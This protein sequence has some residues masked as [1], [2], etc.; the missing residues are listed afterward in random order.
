M[1]S[2]NKGVA[3]KGGGTSCVEEGMYRDGVFGSILDHH[4]YNQSVAVKRS[5]RRLFG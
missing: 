5:W 1:P 2:I 4:W 3:N